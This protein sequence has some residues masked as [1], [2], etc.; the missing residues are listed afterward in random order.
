MSGAL[1]SEMPASPV[2]RA[3]DVLLA[4][5]TDMAV[6]HNFAFCPREGMTFC[7]CYLSVLTAALRC[8]IPPIL[9]NLQHAWLLSDEGRMAG[10]MPVDSE[11]A[12]ARAQ[13]GYPTVAAWP[14]PKHDK[15]GHVALVVPAPQGAVGLYVS[16][17]GA[18]NFLR[19]PLGR[20]FGINKPDMFTH[21]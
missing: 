2:P 17:A 1:V 15:P 3:P 9:A 13:L 5:I 6:T 14:N 4:L 19:A 16:A 7:N 11:T 21:Q 10:W 12:R 20:S 18:E 8:P